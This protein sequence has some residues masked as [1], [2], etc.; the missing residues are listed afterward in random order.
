MEGPLLLMPGEHLA[1][2]GGVEPPADGRCIEAQFRFRGQDEPATDY[3]RACDV[4]TAGYLGLLDVGTG[5][6]LVLGDEPLSTA[7]QPAAD[8]AARDGVDNTGGILIRW[9]YTNSEAD[10][11]GALK[12]V[13]E[14]RW[15]D[16]GLVF[17]VGR[18]PLYLLDATCPASEFERDDHPTI[19]LPPGR[20]ALATAEYAPDDHACLLLHRL[21]RMSSDAAAY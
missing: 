21:T 1:S 2:W 20:Y 10:V 16:E 3:D 5:Q 9:V 14:T 6:G 12:H 18:E 17:S 19:Q 8:A 11:I 4:A 15:Q 13:P 7:W